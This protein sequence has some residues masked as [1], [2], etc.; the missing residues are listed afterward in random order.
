MVIMTMHLSVMV[1]FDSLWLLSNGTWNHIDTS[2][3]RSFEF[4]LC[5]QYVGLLSFEFDRFVKPIQYTNDV[6]T[7]ACFIF[8]LQ[9][10][11]Q[12]NTCLSIEKMIMFDFHCWDMIVFLCC[13]IIHHLFC[14][15]FT[16]TKFMDLCVI[17][18]VAPL[19][20][21]LCRACATMDALPK[22]IH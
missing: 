8:V 13:S 16:R 2:Q 10:R 17:V 21:T 20:L 6:H 4:S 5:W 12:S 15:G 7:V 22:A 1:F 9:K 3:Q 11:S 14:C 19:I 18:L